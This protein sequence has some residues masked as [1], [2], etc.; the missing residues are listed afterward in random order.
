METLIDTVVSALL[1][2]GG[3]FAFLGSLGLARFPDLL[4]RLHGPSKASTLGIGALLIASMI[5]F[6]L[7]GEGLS[8]HELLITLFVVIS[9]PVSAQF[10]AKAARGDSAQQ[11][12]PKSIESKRS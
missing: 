9:T 3:V 8:V 1:I 6:S 11:R 2:F 4:T 10:I 12:A 7:R 5:F